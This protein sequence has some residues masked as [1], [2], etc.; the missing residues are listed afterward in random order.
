MS[1]QEAV[2]AGSFKNWWPTGFLIRVFFYFF[3]SE[4][5]LFALSSDIAK[6]MYWCFKIPH[7]VSEVSLH[8]H[9]GRVWSAVIAHRVI[10]LCIMK[11]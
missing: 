1:K 3:L 11:R 8:K 5:A 10:G 2:V 7:G 4:E 6:M 9:K